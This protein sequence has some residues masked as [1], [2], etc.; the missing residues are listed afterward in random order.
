MKLKYYLKNN[1]KVYTLSEKAPNTDDKT[2]DAHYKYIKKS[3][4]EERLIRSNQKH[5]HLL[6][7][8]FLIL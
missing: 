3:S 4:A 6:K 1:K 5:F 2:Q 8:F 7:V